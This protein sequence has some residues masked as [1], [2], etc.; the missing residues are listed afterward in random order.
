MRVDR[1]NRKSDAG[2]KVL[3]K[4]RTL[5]FDSCCE[6]CSYP[7]G[8]NTKVRG[9]NPWKILKITQKT[10]NY[11][12]LGIW[13]PWCGKISRC[14]LLHHRYPNVLILTTSNLKNAIDM[15]FVDRADLQ[16]YVGPPSV[17]AIYDIFVSCL[18]ELFRVSHLYMQVPVRIPLVA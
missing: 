2:Q 3:L 12:F 10:W 1:W 17:R 5:G 4:C 16:I 6:R 18:E 15:A 9:L 7:V 13:L 14:N 11:V 8:S